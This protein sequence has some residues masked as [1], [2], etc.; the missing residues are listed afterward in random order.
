ML[1]HLL[2]LLSSPRCN[3]WLLKSRRCTSPPACQP[4][5][6]TISSL[7]L[8]R[9]LVGLPLLL[10]MFFFI[11]TLSCTLDF[12]SF[13][14]AASHART[15]SRLVLLLPIPLVRSLVPRTALPRTSWTSRS[16]LSFS[17]CAS[18]SCV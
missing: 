17:V 4:G 3:N 12:L 15:S 11:H 2:Y 14:H 13:G 7:S 5:I 16:R 10:M 6:H 9:L 1:L 18:K 8:H